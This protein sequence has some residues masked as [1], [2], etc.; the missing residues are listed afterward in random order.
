VPSIFNP[1]G[2]LALEAFILSNEHDYNN[3]PM[4]SQKGQRNL[5]PGDFK[6]ID[7]LKKLEDQ[8]VIKPSDKGTNVV[9]MQ[10]DDYEK[11]ARRQL[12]NPS[13]Y[14]HTE[15]DLTEKHRLEISEYIN[16]M[17]K[18]GEID[19]S[20]LICMTQNAKLQISICYLKYTRE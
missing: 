4:F 19:I 15:E 8:I 6:A 3:R 2:P 17:Y 5:T 12:N 1:V 11:E 10:R 16:Q 7:E 14:L 18:D 13:F 20:V 9:I